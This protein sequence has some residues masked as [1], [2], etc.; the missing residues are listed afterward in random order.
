MARSV[1]KRFLT[2][3]VLDR[4]HAFLQR[5]VLRSEAEHATIGASVFLRGAIE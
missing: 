3:V 2:L 4:S 1:G 5:G